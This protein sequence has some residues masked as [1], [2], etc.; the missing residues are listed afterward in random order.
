MKV[1][2]I[3]SGMIILYKNNAFRQFIFL[4]IHIN[5]L[6]SILSKRILDNSDFIQCIKTKTFEWI[7]ENCTYWKYEVALNKENLS[8]FKIIVKQTIAKILYSLEKL[9]A[10]ITFFD[11]ENN[12]LSDL[13][14]QFFM[15]DTIININNL[16][17]PKPSAYIMPHLIINDLEFPFSYYFM[18][19]INYY[20]Y[21]YVDELD[22]LKQDPENIN[23]NK[24]LSEKLV[25]DHLED[26]KNNLIS[27]NPNFENLQKYSKLYYNDFIRIILSTFITKRL[28]SKEELDFIL[29]QLIGDKIINDPFLLHVYWWKYMDNIL[30][31]LKLVEAFPSIIKKVQDDFIVYGKFDQYLFREAINLILKNICDDKPWKHDMDIILSLS[32]KI[33]NA[34][35]SSNLNLLLVCNGLLKINSIPLEKVKEII[36]LGKSTI[37]QEFITADII[38]LLFNSLYGDDDVIPIRS[39]ITRS[40]KLIPLESEIQQILY[41]NIF[42][43]NPFKLIGIIIEK[44]FTTEI[45]QN[46]QIFFT[47]MINS[48]EALYLSI[49]LNAIHN[50]ILNSDTALLCCEIIQSIFNEFEFKELLTHFKHLIKVFAKQ[51]D[52][53]QEGLS[54]QQITLIAFLKNF[55]CKFWMDYIQEDNSLSKSLIEEINDCMNIN[56]F[57]MRSLQSY[58]IYQR[59]FFVDIKQFEMLE[60]IFPCL[61]NYIDNDLPKIWQP[62]RKVNFKDFYNFCNDNL[63]QNLEKYP[64]LSLYFKHYEKIKLIK[65]LHPIIRFVKILNFKF[66]YSLTRKTA[67][68]MTFREFIEKESVDDN[69]NINLKSL[70][71]EFAFGW[72]SVINYIIQYQSK[73]LPFNKPFMNLELPIIFGLIEQKDI[74]IYL[75]AI[76][77]FLIKLHNEF[78]D[79]V[80]AIPVGKSKSL[81]FLECSSWNNSVHKTYFI[82]SIKIIHAQDNHFIDD[83]W[84]DDILKYSQKD[85]KM[86]ENTNFIFDLQKIEMK[87]AK[88]L[89][90]DKVYFEMEDNGFYLKNF[91]F[92]YELFYN[93][94]RI[95]F[96]IKNILSQEPISEDKKLLILAMFQPSNPSFILKNSLNLSELLFFLNIIL[97]FIKE[98]SI[99]NGDIL[100]IDFVNQWL[101]L[102]RY[103]ITYINIFNEFSLKHII[104]LYELIE[105]Q[106]VNLIIHNIEDKFKVSLTE[107]MKD[108]I[109]NCVNYFDQEISTQQLISAESFALALK[110]F[111]YRFLLVESNIEDLNLSIYF[112]DFT[113]DLW[114]SD[115]K[116]ELVERLFPTCLL[117]SHAYNSYIFIV[118]E[119]EVIY[120]FN[121]FLMII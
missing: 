119:I 118:N 54:L 36:Y 55:I 67:Q 89:V 76:L 121:S 63:M 116:Q 29:R 38:N 21:Y 47:L 46:K 7:L 59:N 85:L 73:E 93:S 56:Y 3:I 82:K 17:E 5:F 91:S 84:N 90:F 102:A 6:Y 31:Q 101:K 18:N 13:W 117:V 94:L 83:E 61:E 78:L 98:L 58:F 33:H 100:I 114:T 92:K 77:D 23:H 42:L 19:Q 53:K 115:V 34:K 60:K 62:A 4:I 80:L 32:Y 107:Q 20:K 111:I 57:Y 27:I 65:Y 88:K 8:S 87:L 16:P 68:I 106:V 75:C 52:L 39:L 35:K 2:E 11:I 28:I 109:N 79:N 70:F 96:D 99:K 41:K 37:K 103:D 45:Q 113:L 24:E 86:G 66:E 69:E 105:E 74:G 44:I 1:I 10:T 110:R 9:S 43:R 50:N 22:M 49:G 120:S 64:F 25:E 40:L 81:Q 15:D 51:E 12:E 14:K 104:A 71:E 112:L 97:C 48:E 108:T 30:I 26:F 95:L 72:N